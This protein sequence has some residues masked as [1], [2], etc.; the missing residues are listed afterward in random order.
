M[1]L[2]RPREEPGVAQPSAGRAPRCGYC[3]ISEAALPFGGGSLSHP[4]ER[5]GS[6]AEPSR[7]AVRL[8][9]CLTPGGYKIAM[10]SSGS[11]LGDVR[12]V[13]PEATRVSGRRFVAHFVDGVLFIVLFLIALLVVGLLPSGTIAF[14][15]MMSSAYRQR[16]GDRWGHTYVVRSR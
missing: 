7:Q 5:P 14:I 6:P 12:R 15:G 16:M 2:A 4:G 11:E 8:L 10:V 3:A 13:T 1:V 9:L